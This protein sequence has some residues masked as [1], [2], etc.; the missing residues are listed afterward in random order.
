ME[1]GYVC[2]GEVPEFLMAIRTPETVSPDLPNGLAAAVEASSSLV[3]PAVPQEKFPGFRLG[4][5]SMVD[6]QFI[7]GR[8]CHPGP[9]AS[10]YFL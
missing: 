1:Q 3:L 5:R 10:N 6:K 4:H 8:I 7:E 9:I 2:P